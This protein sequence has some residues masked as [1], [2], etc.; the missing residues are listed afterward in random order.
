MVPP[1]GQMLNQQPRMQ[2]P[3]VIPTSIRPIMDPSGQIQAPR[4]IIHMQMSVEGKPTNLLTRMI[5]PKDFICVGTDCP[6]R[7]H[8]KIKP[9]EF[10]A[11][12]FT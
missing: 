3:Q 9:V 6:N 2:Q 11:L 1:N 10:K 12:Q 5:P 8:R 4:P 7:K